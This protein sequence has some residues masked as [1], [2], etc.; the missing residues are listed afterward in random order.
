MLKAMSN[1]T[2]TNQITDEHSE[3]FTSIHILRYILRS[4][5]AICLYIYLKN[6]LKSERCYN[7]FAT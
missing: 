4:A 7:V 6:L 1:V 2:H 5:D 3:Q